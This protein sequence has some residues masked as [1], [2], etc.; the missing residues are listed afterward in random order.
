MP[1]IL[2]IYL[3]GDVGG[4]KE[5]E[6]ETGTVIIERF[7]VEPAHSWGT[8]EESWTLLMGKDLMRNHNAVEEQVAKMAYISYQVNPALTR[9]D[10]L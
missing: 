5:Y 10:C 8:G 9:T 1:T 4:A 6:K 2:V 3:A 7:R